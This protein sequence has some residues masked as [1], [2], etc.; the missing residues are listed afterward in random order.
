[1]QINDIRVFRISYFSMF[2]ENASINESFVEIRVEN[3][4][5]WAATTIDGNANKY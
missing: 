1:M 4:I 5:R 3:N 2:K